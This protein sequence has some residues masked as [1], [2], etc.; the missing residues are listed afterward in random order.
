MIDKSKNMP[1]QR[2]LELLRGLTP[3]ADAASLIER[4][5]AGTSSE[6]EWQ[7]SGELLLHND[8]S[9]AV[10]LLAAAVDSMPES[11]GLHY[12][13][14][15]ALRVSARAD[16]AESALR[17][18]LLLDPAHANASTSLAHL[19]REQGRMKALA[20]VMQNAWRNQPRTLENDQKILAFLCQC[21]RFAEADSL[22]PAMLAAHPQ[23]PFLLRQAGEIALVLGRFDEARKHLRSSLD[24]DPK[25]ASAW[26][27]LAHTHR[28][29]DA[30]DADVSLFTAATKRSDLGIEVSTSIGFGLGKALDDLGRFDE[31]ATVFNRANS[32]WRSSHPWDAGAWQQ[33]VTTQTNSLAQIR[34][35][36]D[37]R[38]DSD[39][40]PVFI[41]GLPRSGTTLVESL[42]TRDA[43]VRGRGELNWMAPLA[44][45]LGPNPSAAML[46][47]AAD[48]LLAQL[49]QDDTPARF[50]IDK[51]PL[52]FR[53]L[54]LINAMLPGAKIIHCRRNPRDTALSLW[55]QHFAHE[56]LAWSYDF[57]DIGHYMGGY[58]ALMT[59]W[60]RVLPNPVFTLDYE[61]LVEDSEA[62]IAQVR[63]FLGLEATSTP[64]AQEHTRT[65]TT[66]ST[67][68]ARQEVHQNSVGRWRHY[69][70]HLPGLLA[71]A[72]R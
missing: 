61:T 24:A 63:A 13:L 43:Q 62:S 50:I 5:Q 25:Q 41:V 42:L 48:F 45:Q 26:L 39:I 66:A 49:R 65:I 38:S 32:D 72:E 57:A 58:D 16:E 1:V 27:R 34:A 3:A 46:T 23:D 29:T 56:D 14:G 55:S 68:Q 17:K 4:L 10:S 59:H 11:P 54:S 44:R 37:S 70:A 18:A 31:A 52:N 60:H 35:R 21:E 7:D 71:I 67:W 51:N 12:L 2:A 9:A 15:N 69:Q 6:S 36:N 19:L 30:D 8:A 47:S 20:E 33:F 22:I 64:P 28:F 53:H 40:T